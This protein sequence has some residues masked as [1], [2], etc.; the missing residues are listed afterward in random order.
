MTAV[1][2]PAAR[3]PPGAPAPTKRAT[4]KGWTRHVALGSALVAVAVIVVLLLLPTDVR[5]ALTS[6]L[7]TWRGGSS[8]GLMLAYV[9]VLMLTA[10]QFYTLVKRA[11]APAYTKALG[12]AGRWLSIHIALSVLGLLLVLV[13]AGFPFR[14]RSEDLA[15]HGYAALAT[16]LLLI[17]TVSGIFGRYLYRRL[18]VFKRP[19][20]T[21]QPF[22][23][24]TTVLLFAV[25]I[26]HMATAD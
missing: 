10:A 16:I 17:V 20:R 3:P 15:E 24:V 11:G 9:G 22:H 1:P 18:P 25:S 13:H 14:F 12:G 19:F 26:V 6:A 7:R 23:A 8:G 4:R 2:T 21:W 5:Q